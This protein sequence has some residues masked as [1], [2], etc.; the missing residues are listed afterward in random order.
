MNEVISVENLGKKY[1]ISHQGSAN[2][3]FREMITKSAKNIFKNK[4]FKNNRKEE[5]WAL[6][7]VSFQVDKGDRIGIIGRNGSGKSTL[8][9]LLSR[10]TEPTEGKIRI[11]GKIAS[12]LEVG[13]GFHPELTGRE[14][15][16][17]N[18]AVLGMSKSEIKKKFDNIVAFSGVEQFL[19]TPV[20][21]YS[22]GMYVRLGFA[23][24]AHLETEILAI[25]EV[26][27]VGD[28]KFQ[29]KCLDKME[30][31][32]KNEG[33]TVLFVSHNMAAISSLCKRTVVLKNGKIDF[34]GDVESGVNHY[35]HAIDLRKG[36][37]DLQ[38]KKSNLWQ[39]PKAFSKLLSIET[40]NEMDERQSFFNMGDFLKI[41]IK[42]E[43][44]DDREDI[45]VGVFFRDHLEATSGLVSSAAEGFKNIQKGINDL[46]IE[47]PEIKLMPGEYALGIWIVYNRQVDDAYEN[48][49]SIDI[50]AKRFT[51]NEIDFDRFRGY[52][53]LIR[54]NWE[55]VK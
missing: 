13:T 50:I 20:K 53:S 35:L 25:D 9:K 42:L 12:L 22:S 47:I 29:K 15:I 41:K 26:L 51:G 30:D 23:V 34:A 7:N 44:T 5:F 6:K 45:E 27:A 54:S 55:T 1:I 3:T 24:A 39:Q 16:Y 33:R 28:F 31:I 14:N 40:L 46:Q 52:G 18:G 38:N 17:L 49:V 4:S 21:R 32:S 8:L 37:A 36:F 19:D 2:D 11:R 10:I 48:A 43:I